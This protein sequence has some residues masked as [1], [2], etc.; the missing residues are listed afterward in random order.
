MIRAFVNGIFP[1]PKEQAEKEE[2][3]AEKVEEHAEK[4]E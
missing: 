4:E 1:F 3:H 2:E